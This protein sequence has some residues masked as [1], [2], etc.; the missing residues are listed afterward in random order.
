MFA[1]GFWMFSNRQMFENHVVL[2]PEAN[3]EVEI[4]GHTVFQNITSTPAVILFYATLI[5][6][7]GLLFKRVISKIL[8]K[9]P[10]LIKINQHVDE[11]LPNYFEALE[12][13]DSMYMMSLERHLRK[14]YGLK[15]LMD[16]SLTQIVT[17]KPCHRKISGIGVYDILANIRYCDKFQYDYYEQVFK[18][19]FDEESTKIKLWLSLGYMKKDK[20]KERKTGG[21]LNIFNKEFT[22]TGMQ[23]R[24][25]EGMI[26]HE[27]EA[28]LEKKTNQIYNTINKVERVILEEDFI[29]DEEEFG[30]DDKSESLLKN[31]R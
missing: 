22:L 5:T 21:L 31:Y 14:H 24:V 25:F 26:S 16:Q 23:Q 20:N 2:S 28:E 7:F 8:Q 10:C 9:T 13:D 6:L 3:P 12:Y 4:T 1:V 18:M 27:V 17:A 29:I 15:T 19:N 30:S 11:H